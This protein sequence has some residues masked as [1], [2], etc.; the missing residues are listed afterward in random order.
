MA[1]TTHEV[2]IKHNLDEYA[3]K[4]KESNDLWDVHFVK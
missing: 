4:I 3:Q 2:E 1:D